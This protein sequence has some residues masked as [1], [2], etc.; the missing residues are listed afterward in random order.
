MVLA[1]GCGLDS[2]IVDSFD[3]ELLRI[4]RVI[5]K[6]TAQNSYDKLYLNLYDMMQAFDD[7]DSIEYDK[8]D[9]EQVKIFKTAE[10]LLN[11]KVYT[12]SY[13]EI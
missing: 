10:I 13:L 4:N 6:Q 5:E 12:N 9:I 2:A 7:T 3:S 8:T 11:K 1:M